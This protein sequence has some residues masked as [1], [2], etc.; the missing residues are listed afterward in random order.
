MAFESSLRRNI[1]VIYQEQLLFIDELSFR[2]E[3]F[4]RSH[5]RSPVGSPVVVPAVPVREAQISLIVA[6]DVN[7]YVAHVI[8]EGHFN[9]HGFVQFL[10]DMITSRLISTFGG[11]RSILVLDG[12]KFHISPDLI[13][14]IRKTG[15]LYWILPP[16][17][18][19][20]NP[21][22]QFFRQFRCRVRDFSHL[23]PNVPTFQKLQTILT[24]M[25][26]NCSAMFEHSGWFQGKYYSSPYLSG[27][28]VQ[29]LLKFVE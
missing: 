20:S 15:A 25:T 28:R 5:G 2:S 21:I 1:G 10:Q 3:H 17:S 18:P 29:R 22:E 6:I 13:E 27:K 8:Q 7:G 24:Q 11:R 23:H 9:R 12:C 4:Q 19:E 14:G 26:Y 16:Y